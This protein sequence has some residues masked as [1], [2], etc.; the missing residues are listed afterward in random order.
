MIKALIY[1]CE[2]IRA[3][4]DRNEPPIPGIEYCKGWGD[5]ANMGVSV[6]GAYD[7]AADRYR[8]FSKDNFE[9]FGALARSSDLLVGFNNIGFDDKLI[10]ASN[11][12]FDQNLLDFIVVPRYDILS[13]TWVAAG[14]KPTWGGGAYGGYSLDAICKATL[15][16]AKTGNGAMAPI[17]W[18][19]GE[20]GKVIDYCL[21]DIKLTK[22]LFDL[23]LNDVP[24]RNPKTGG[25]LTLR[26]P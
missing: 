26:K 17:W 16:E 3:I 23:A 9:E 22:R 12:F 21:Q 11:I 19:R 20:I 5:H 6:I 1:D 13:E 14:L 25:M 18:Q 8:V 4:P 10:A 2:I 15:G 24:I 7:Y